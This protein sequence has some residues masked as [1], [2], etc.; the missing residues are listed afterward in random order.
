LDLSVDL[1]RIA[2]DGLAVLVEDPALSAVLVDVRRSPS[3]AG[4]LVEVP[5][6]YG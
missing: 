2:A 1:E 4:I 6:I 5:V 3:F